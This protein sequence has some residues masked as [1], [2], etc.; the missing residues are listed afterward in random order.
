MAYSVKK[1]EVCSVQ[2]F[3]ACSEA[4]PVAETALKVLSPL[5]LSQK[6]CVMQKLKSLKK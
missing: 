4:L 1:P 5:S 3:A 2:K 6:A